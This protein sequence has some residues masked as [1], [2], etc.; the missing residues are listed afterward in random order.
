MLFIYFF[1]C[2]FCFN[3]FLFFS[4]SF[5]LYYLLQRK[6]W[7]LNEF[8]PIGYFFSWLVPLVFYLQN[9]CQTQGHLNFIL[10]YFLKVL[11][12]TVRSVIHYESFVKNGRTVFRIFFLMWMSNCCIYHMLKR[13]SL[14]HC[15]AFAPLLRVSWLHLC[16]SI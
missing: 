16:E 15:M 12:F 10:C 7:N 9:P 8:Q 3:F 6:V 13:L 1:V 5:F 2:S 14:L 4:L 11:H